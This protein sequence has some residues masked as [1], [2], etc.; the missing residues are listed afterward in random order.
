MKEELKNK[1]MENVKEASKVDAD[2]TKKQKEIKGIEEKKLNESLKEK[3]KRS[4]LLCPKM[5]VEIKICKKAKEFCKKCSD[6]VKSGLKRKKGSVSYV[7]KLA[8][9][10]TGSVKSVVR[11]PKA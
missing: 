1:T 10:I 9:K 4:L 11:P 8:E 5:C 6:T 7:K 3:V 2:I